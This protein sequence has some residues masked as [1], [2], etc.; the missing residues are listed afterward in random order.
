MSPLLEALILLQNRLVVW[1]QQQVWPLLG[2]N[3]QVMA[4]FS[5]H[6]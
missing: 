4:F 1:W 3:K 6:L 2:I 5:G